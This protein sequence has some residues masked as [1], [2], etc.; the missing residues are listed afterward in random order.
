MLTTSYLDILIDRIRINR[1]T[2]CFAIY[3]DNS[4]YKTNLL[5]KACFSKFSI[6]SQRN[7]LERN[8][9]KESVERFACFLHHVN[10]VIFSDITCTRPHNLSHQTLIFV[11]LELSICLFQKVILSLFLRS[12]VS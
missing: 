10:H 1:S 2:S 7:L 5:I 4:R 6:N 11:F 9:S 12:Q 8:I 3:V